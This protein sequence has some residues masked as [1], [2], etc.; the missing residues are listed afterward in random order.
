MRVMTK[1]ALRLLAVP[2][3]VLGL[4]LG[5]A[6]PASAHAALVG[7]DPAQG[8]VVKTAPAQVRLSF[9]E[10]VLLSRDSIRVLGPDGK[11]AET[12]DANDGGRGSTT[13]A[14]ALRPGLGD[15]TYTVAWKVVSADSHPVAGAFTFSIG[16]PSKT[17]VQLPDQEV[18]GGAVGTLYDIARYAA[19]LG[20]ALLVGAAFFIGVC[21]PDGA[22]TRSMRRLVAAGWAA[23]VAATILLLMLR[24]PYANGGGLGDAFDLGGVRDVLDTRPGAALV[25]RLL[26]LAAGAVF[27]AV[28]FGSWAKREDPVERQD[29]AWGLA[30]GGTVVSV[31]LAATWAMAEHASVGIQASVAMPVDIVH[32]LAMAVWLGGLTALLVALWGGQSVERAVVQRFSKIAFG[33]VVTLVVTG[34]YQSWRQL[35]SWDALVSTGYG[36]LLLVKIGLVILLVELAWLS[37]RWTARLGDTTVRGRTAVAQPV[38]VGRKGGGGG[39][40]SERAEQLARQQAALA[41]ERARKDRDADTE[42]TGLRK[43]VLAEVAVAVVVLAVTT[44]LTGTQPGRAAEE[45]AAQQAS[46]PVSEVP[47]PL[48]VKIPFDTGGTNGKGEAEVTLDPGGVAENELHLL[49]TAPDGRAFDVPE[50]QVSFT[51]KSKK[52][53][54]I[55]VTLGK[56]DTG[57]WSAENVQI[58]V[59]GEWTVAVTVRTSDIDQVTRTKVVKIGS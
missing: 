50:V 7:S 47:E 11:R 51:L 6:A 16:A 10:G 8:S 55:P 27:I 30:I 41:K 28:L 21:W 44:L 45:G 29:L 3:A 37:R 2:L 58:P 17:S 38:A 49:V 53:G 40:A 57:H 5:T 26:L 34:V 54:P 56:I 33:A 20:F 9:S 12:G 42:R 24:A 22:R 35:G 13:A 48:D 4:L 25:S 52:I 31:G 39:G 59:P 46:A 1:S 32:L 15:G 23:M 18:G 14:V 19:Y 36:Q 43:S